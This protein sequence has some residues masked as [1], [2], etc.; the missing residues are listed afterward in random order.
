MKYS[1]IPSKEPFTISMGISSSK[2]GS[3]PM[4]NLKE[5]IDSL[6][7]LTKSSRDFSRI[8]TLLRSQSIEKYWREEVCLDLPTEV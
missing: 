2:K 7:I 1:A 5:A 3:L 4:D 6:T 8:I